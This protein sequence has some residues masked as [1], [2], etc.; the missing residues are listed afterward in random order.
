[1][2][3]RKRISRLLLWMLSLLLL[4]SLPVWPAAAAGAEQNGE[5]LTVGVPADRCPIFYP[6]PDSGEPIGIGVDLMRFAAGEAGYSVS[7]RFVGE[8]TLKEALDNPEYD[9]IMPLGSA[10]TSAAGQASVISEN[11]FQ[12]PFTFVTQGDRDLPPLEELRVGMLRSL[13]GAVDTLHQLYPKLAILEFETM[14]ESVRALRAGTVDALLH[15]SYVW[16][17]VLQKP[18]YSDLF[19]QPSTMFSMDFRAGTRDTPQ[20]QE[21]IR[22]INGG[23]AALT[24]P[25]RQAVILDY[26]SRSLYRYDLSDY[27][28]RYGLVVLLVTLL[29]AALIIIV[30]Q[31]VR[32]VRRKQEE[33]LRQMIEYDSLTGVLSHTG[34]RERVKELLSA[35]PDAPYYLSYSNIRNF[36][37]INENLGRQAGDDLLRFWANK[38]R[39]ALSQEEAIGRIAA[40]HFAVLR[41]IEGEKQ[42]QLDEEK[43]FRPIQRFFLDQGRE[44][45]VQITCGIYVLTPKDFRDI[46]VDHLLDLARVAEKK[47]REDHS[48]NY[49]FYNP[50][51]WER[52]KRVADIVSDLPAALEAGELQVWYQPQVDS[53]TGAVTGAEALSRW[54]H[55]RLGR[56]EPSGFIPTLEEAGLIYELDSYVWDRVCRDLRRWKD[57]GMRRSVSVNVS[58]DDIREERDVPGQFRQLMRTYGLTPDQLRIEI[59]ETAYA[60]DAGL[61]LETTEKFRAL[62]FQVEMDDFGSGSSSL[63]MLK[64]VPVDRV[65]LDLD[66]L[67]EAGDQDK[68]RIIVSCIIRMVRQLGIGLIAEGV[69]TREQAEF[70]RSQ[71]C[72][73]MQGYYFYKPMPVQEFE[74]VHT[75]YNEKG[76][77]T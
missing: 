53:E 40:D 9:L 43:V 73:E 7:F 68:G 18:A 64:E 37:F 30:V 11:L 8:T 41:L 16:S 22:R 52:G 62:G 4:Y 57:Q 3:K 72:R 45:R 49:T 71:G 21:L 32:S 56:L 15:N 39:D 51:Q 5:P 76:A 33:T 13:G 25:R 19:V 23:I 29:A 75:M 14:D 58:R 31:W 60:G 35:H 44:E 63:H 34:F 55:S 74:K 24:D 50:E 36:K 48:R 28:T 69:E 20:G 26:T 66:F 27:L 67:T 46:D 54:D 38:S 65:K 10:I 12:T 59:T 17:Y 70:L 61:V 1:M 2:L 6:D 42:M 77:A 47:A